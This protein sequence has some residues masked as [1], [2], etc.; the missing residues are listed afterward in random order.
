VILDVRDVLRTNGVP[1]G[2][3]GSAPRPSGLVLRP[4][5]SRRPDSTAARDG[6][7]PDGPAP[8]V[9]GDGAVGGCPGYYWRS[10]VALKFSPPLREETV[11]LSCPSSLI[12]VIAVTPPALPRADRWPGSR[13]VDRVEVGQR[14]DAAARGAAR[15]LDDDLAEDRGAFARVPVVVWLQPWVLSWMNRLKWV[16]AG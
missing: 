8:A 1:I 14:Q 12:M 3:P 7:V 10:Q 4:R 5:R 16:A 11:S 6:L 13:D 9:S 2:P 15:R